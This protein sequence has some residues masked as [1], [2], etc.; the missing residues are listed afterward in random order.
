MPR[1]GG[2]GRPIPI[3]TSVETKSTDGVV[4]CSCMCSTH[5][6]MISLPVVEVGALMVRKADGGTLAVMNAATACCAWDRV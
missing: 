2:R 5:V 1:S 6:A 4:E 3:F